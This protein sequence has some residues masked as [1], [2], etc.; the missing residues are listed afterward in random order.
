[1]SEKILVVDDDEEFAGLMGLLLTK[2]G[3]DTEV[4]LGGVQALEIAAKFNPS[5][6]VQDYML[7]DYR[8]MDLLKEFKSR[9]PGIYVIIITAKGNEEVAVELLTSGASDYLK[10]PFEVD[11]LLKTIENV[12]RLRASESDR[13]RMT[14]EITQQNQELMALNALSA[15]LTSGMPMAEKCKA[16]AGI[17][18]KNLRVDLVNLF[19]FEA[20]G[21][22]LTLL[23]SEGSNMDAMEGCGPKANVGISSYV[24]ETMKPA[25][26]VDFGAEKRFTVPDAIYDRGLTSALAVP[27]LVR[28][29]A[30]GALVVYSTERRTFPAFEMKLM[31]SFGNLIAM[32]MENEALLDTTARTQDDWQSAIDALPGS[33]VVMDTRHVILKA[34]G[35]A[36]GLAGSNVR[37]I[38]GQEWCWLLHGKKGPI[39]DCPVSEAIS[40]K[41]PVYKEL[42]LEVP[43]GRFQIWAEPVLDGSGDVVS[44]MEFVRKVS[45]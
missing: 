32:A 36:A 29:A 4:A 10:K 42:T 31:N 8:G 13:D 39:K 26:V 38:I 22:T 15:T 28:G 20:K 5:I 24:V 25:V 2:K 16:A 14:V 3:Y 7:P 12:L 40:T 37:D 45:S 41:K 23:A 21:R 34:N 9:F 43:E 6:I 27:L 17:V 30:K 19:S 18:L 11:K 44:V 1:M 33:F 35:T